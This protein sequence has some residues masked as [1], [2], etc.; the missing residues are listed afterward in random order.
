MSTTVQDPLV[1]RHDDTQHT[2]S[3]QLV[4]FKLGD[5]TFGIEIT[6]IREIILVGEITQ[7]PETPPYTSYGLV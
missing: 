6:K 5:E 7:V 3:M 4:S 1:P 2:G